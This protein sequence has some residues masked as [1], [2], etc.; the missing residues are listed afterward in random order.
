MNLV[1]GGCG[2]RVFAGADWCT[3]C[4]APASDAV[5]ASVP[6]TMPAPAAVMA[7]PVGV[8][9]GAGADGDVPLQPVP[10]RRSA[11]E[12]WGSPEPAAASPGARSAG[13]ARD[14]GYGQ[15]WSGGAA[16]SGAWTSPA[17][18]VPYQVSP[19]HAG[20]GL[21]WFGIRMILVFTFVGALGVVFFLGYGNQVAIIGSLL[22]SLMVYAFVHDRAKNRLR[23]S[24]FAPAWTVGDKIESILIGV[25]VGGGLITALLVLVRPAN[26]RVSVDEGVLALVGGRSPLHVVLAFLT[27]GV[28]APLV[29]ELLFRGTIGEGIRQRSLAKGAVISSVLFSVAHGGALAG[30]IVTLATG[31]AVFMTPFIYYFVGGLVFFALYVKRGL[32]ASIAAHAA[33]NGVIVVTAVMVAWGPAQRVDNDGV[34]AKVPGS[35]QELSRDEIPD[36][37][38]AFASEGSNLLLAAGSPSGGALIV[39]SMT[40][41]DGQTVGVDAFIANLN[42][43][44]V[45]PAQAV[46]T[47][48]YPMGPAAAVDL[49]EDGERARIL[50]VPQ[51]ST[52][53]IVVVTDGG[54]GRMQGEWDAIL[55]SVALPAA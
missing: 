27:A 49:H 39:A 41:P 24:S 14:A 50:Y 43:S 5:E 51:G 53:W 7:P 3:Q 38:D 26:G 42:A 16:S 46:L 23:N 19:L 28:A 45:L 25:L 52:V 33:F 1:C 55:R 15:G 35:W 36:A 21:V 48:D 22:W 32:V 30:L 29:E 37:A 18:T 13:Y 40:L 20:S 44:A 9:A 54:S 12:S 34:T 4:F 6:S 47:Y 8:P 11:W 2:A 31:K 17:D 10:A